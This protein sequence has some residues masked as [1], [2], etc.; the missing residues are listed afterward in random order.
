MSLTSAAQ[1]AMALRM[2]AHDLSIASAAKP[3]LIHEDNKGAM[4]MSMNPALHQT[5][6]HIDI[7]HH[8]IREKC[9][10]GDVTLQ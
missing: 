9:A 3:T 4:A 2:L 1:E 6:K 7:K 5:A 10:N 8:F